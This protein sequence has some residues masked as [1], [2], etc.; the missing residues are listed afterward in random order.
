MLQWQRQ[1]Q[2]YDFW[3][4][5]GKNMYINCTVQ[6][7]GTE[8]YWSFIK[9]P[10]FFSCNLALGGLC[11]SS[12]G[13]MG[14]SDFLLYP[15]HT[16]RIFVMVFAYTSTSCNSAVLFQPLG[17]RGNRKQAYSDTL[18]L[19]WE[20]LVLSTH[21]FLGLLLPKHSFKWWSLLCFLVSLFVNSFV[22]V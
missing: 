7:T 20:E 3:T 10:G 1:I 16:L 15:F 14:Y 5:E 22:S 12:G 13:H 19:Q 21:L 6:H 18:E 17:P 8:V 11:P 2:S 9:S 4:C